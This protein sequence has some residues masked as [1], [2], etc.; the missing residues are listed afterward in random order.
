[1]SNELTVGQRFVEKMKTEY[2][3]SVGETKLSESQKSLVQSYFISIDST[4]KAAEIG[5]SK[6]SGQYQEKLPVKWENVDTSD[7][8][9]KLIHYSKLGLNPL[10]S[11]HMFFIPYKNKNTN[12]YD[13]TIIEGYRGIEIKAMKYGFN[14]PSNVVAEVVRENDTFKVIKK[15][16]NNPVESYTFEMSDPFNRGEIVGGFWYKEYD[17]ETRN[18]IKVFSIADIKKRKP[19]Y[20]SVEFWGGQ[21][22]EWK[23]GSKTG[24]KI[25][26]EGWVEEMYLKTIL[27]N[28]YNS[29]P[30]DASKIDGTYNA[31]AEDETEYEV[32]SEE[33][34]II[35]TPVEEPKTI[36]VVVDESNQKDTA[37]EVAEGQI[38]L[39]VDT[40]KKENVEADF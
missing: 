38:A 16:R 4:I 18:N 3:A 14:P 26:V 27:R 32:Y 15:D 1:M 13:M 33:T 19:T 36:D 7:L 40:T 37:N 34:P 8:A 9:R 17:D 24:K 20:A 35:G 31:I 12:K 5:R 2:A 29:I 10:C 28:A 39:D 6:K 21:K 23:N 22:D 25:D 11:N 30:L